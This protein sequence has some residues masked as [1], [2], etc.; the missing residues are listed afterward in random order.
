MFDLGTEIRL[1]AINA[2]FKMDELKFRHQDRR[3]AI[4]ERRNKQFGMIRN[5][6]KYTAEEYVHTGRVNPFKAAA[7]VFVDYCDEKDNK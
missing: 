4:K 2:R 3:D 5:G 1:A 6:L 7:K